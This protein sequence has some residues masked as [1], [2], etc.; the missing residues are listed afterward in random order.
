VDCAGLATAVGDE[1]VLTRAEWRVTDPAAEV[2][3]LA[4]ALYKQHGALRFVMAQIV[5]TEHESVDT[6]VVRSRVRLA[7]AQ[8][9]PAA[10]RLG[11]EM[12]A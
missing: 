1:H 6:A 2:G 4:A 5:L 11:H 10:E 9:E 8:H 3:E 7:L 12:R